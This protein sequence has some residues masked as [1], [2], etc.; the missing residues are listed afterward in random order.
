MT[1]I[2]GHVSHC[3]AAKQVERTQ[4]EVRA[5]ALHIH[6]DFLTYQLAAGIHHEQDQL[7][8][9]TDCHINLRQ[10][11]GEIRMLTHNNPDDF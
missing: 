4:L 1:N 5:F 11:G 9:L 2:H 8:I 7:G 3:F 10:L 6:I